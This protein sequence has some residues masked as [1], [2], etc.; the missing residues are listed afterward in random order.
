MSDPAGTA[1][2]VQYYV[3]SSTFGGD[4]D[5]LFLDTS[6]GNVGIGT[7]APSQ[8][9]HV[10]GGQILTKNASGD[11]SIKVWAGGTSDP[12]IQFTVD[13]ATDYVIGLDNSDSDALKFCR[14][15]AVGT[16][17]Q[18]TIDSNGKVGVG[19]DNP[20]RTLHVAASATPAIGISVLDSTIT[21]TQNIGAIYFGGSEDSGSTWDHGAAIAAYA[22]EDWTVGSAAG[23]D[24]TFWTIPKTTSGSVERMRILDDGKV[25]IGNS[26]PVGLLHLASDYGSTETGGLYIQNEGTA[27]ADDVSPIAFTTRSSDWGTVHAAT[28]AAGTQ[29]ATTGGAYL[30]L[31]TSST[32]Q[33]APTERMRIGSDGTVDLKNKVIIR[34]DLDLYNDY[35]IQYWKKANGTDNLGWIL[36]RD[37]N[38]CQY[39]WSSGQPLMFGTT[40]TGGSTSEKVRFL[41][42]GMVGINEAAPDTTNG[43]ILEVKSTSN[44]TTSAIRITNK[45]TSAGTDQ[46]AALDFGLSRNSGAFKPQAG[47]IAVRRALD[48]TADDAN[49]DAFMTFSVYE[50]NA[51]S[52]KM[53]IN[54]NG[55][56]G[57]GTD[58][59]NVKLHLYDSTINSLDLL[60]LETAADS[61]DDYV[62]IKFTSGV[63]GSGPHAAIRVYGGPA[64]GD[65]YMSLLTTSDGGTLT[66]G[67]TQ[68]H[69]GWVGIGT[70]S[71][72]RVLELSADTNS[73]VDLFRLTNADTT[74]AQTVDFSLDTNKDLVIAGSSGNGGLH[75]NM[76]S[77]G[78]T[79]SNGNVGIGMTPGSTYGLYV[80]GK[81]VKFISNGTAASGSV[82][83][84]VHANNDSTDVVSTLTFAN[85]V[86]GVA[87]IQGGTTGGNTN[88]YISFLTDNAGTSTEKMR[89]DS[90]G[91]LILSG[92]GGSTTNSLDFSYNG[93]SGQGSINADSN[94][95]N[96]YI[97]FGTS[98]S[99]TLSEKMKINSGG[100][101]GINTAAAGSHPTMRLTVYEDNGSTIA[102]I[103][104]TNQTDSFISFQG[105]GTSA[106]STVRIGANGDDLNAYVGGGYRLTVLGSNGN[107]GIVN[108]SPTERLDVNG[109]ALVRGNI[110]AQSP[111]GVQADIV[112]TG[113]TANLTVQAGE[114]NIATIQLSSDDGDDA[115]DITILEQSNGG[116]FKI[117][118]NN[119]G[120][121][122]IS[123]D[124]GGNVAINQAT[125]SYALDVN[126]V[127]N[128]TSLRFADGTSIST[129]PTGTVLLRDLNPAA[130]N[131]DVHVAG[132]V[133]I[134]TTSP[135][136]KLHVD[137]T[138][139]GDDI[140]FETS[141]DHDLNFVLEAGTANNQFS[142]RIPDEVDRLEF[143]ADSNIRMTLL[144]NGNFGIG[145]TNPTDN[146][147]VG[148]GTS[149]VGITINK[150]V[151]GTGALEFENAGT[152]KCYIRCNSTEDLIFGTGDSDRV[153]ILE[154]G[155][156]G[157][158]TSN[159]SFKTEI[160]GDT[161]AIHDGAS[162][163]SGR[164][165]FDEQSN[166]NYG[167][168]VGYSGV[169]NKSFDGTDDGYPTNTFFIARHNNSK[170]FINVMMSNRDNGHIGFGSGW[171]SGSS[172]Y[173]NSFLHSKG[174]ERLGTNARGSAT[175][176][177]LIVE[178][179]GGAANDRIAGMVEIEYN[180]TGKTTSRIC[181]R[182]T[183]F[184]SKILFL[185]SNNYSSGLNG[186]PLTLSYNARIGINNESPTATLDIYNDPSF[187]STNDVRLRRADNQSTY[188]EWN[189]TGGTCNFGTQGSDHL[190]FKT[191]GAARMT[192]HASN[193]NVGIATT[194]PAYRLDV[195][196]T[197]RCGTLIFK[198]GTSFSSVGAVGNKAI[199]VNVG[200]GS[201]NPEG[202]AKSVVDASYGGIQNG[203]VLVY[204]HY[205]YS[206]HCGNGGCTRT[207]YA[208]R[209]YQV[210]DGNWSY[211]F[212]F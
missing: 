115:S 172:A 94:S 11:A 110:K 44:S 208:K 144:D 126:G 34:D 31:K 56:V 161:L 17:T 165:L 58:S 88:G 54:A 153:S 155:R 145:T 205:N 86:G 47:K 82:L 80:S 198:D 135:A 36:N 49:I 57:I 140:K 4:K 149:S 131:Y 45:D 179:T 133:G 148:D 177:G 188:A 15:S 43:N 130:F 10:E 186:Q 114:A 210:V 141:T 90:S 46:G 187:H 61:V 151:S 9:L 14:S 106:S 174:P 209:A 91:T 19:T 181:T 142:L 101:V 157:I 87:N 189:Y 122:A 96:T 37:D 75:F 147:T 113:S 112:S 77:R 137:N 16:S 73:T 146:L 78:Y 100:S 53:R 40:T 116:P 190:A 150:S 178:D 185:T 69:N 67:L 139:G 93:T 182:A 159:P 132:K 28:I 119:G 202:R 79:F 123:C 1:G 108:Q 183:N 71:P 105:S 20:L 25:G 33:Y 38:S 102:G 26:S 154:S 89:I 175:K 111:S 29:S 42:N 48:W 118:T 191:N 156:V 18:M 124:S 168:S 35:C 99:G 201:S 200:G 83:E 95:G 211:I 180:P 12:R 184:G 176:L 121:T 107:V 23:T 129:T 207:A 27:T 8:K 72:V 164:I 62:G 169:G 199:A 166:G 204:Y 158:G 65:S 163:G 51:L 24:L 59:P 76:G 52:E 138:T 171:G 70:T 194:N 30:V 85:N 195:D 127:V 6:N 68:I 117:K 104:K 196:G 84:L 5:K 206:S 66:Q 193:G 2:A 7:D 197:I 143:M 173:P 134:G 203:L 60:H 136:A 98:S 109:N 160:V 63:G 97:T 162:E 74:Y 13:S 167:F 212:G 39:M 50:N 64:S 92:D 55:N 21:D 22:A 192:L 41:N 120:S 128:C 103:F 3:N 152:D 125:A 81:P 170:N 32:G